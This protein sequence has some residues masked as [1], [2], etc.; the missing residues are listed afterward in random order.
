MNTQSQKQIIRN[1]LL[2]GGK[3]TSLIA[4]QIAGSLRASERIRELEAD[5]MIIN[6]KRINVNGKNL[7]EYSLPEVDEG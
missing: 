3:L 4:L 1:Y 5:G 2:N 6:H 7:M